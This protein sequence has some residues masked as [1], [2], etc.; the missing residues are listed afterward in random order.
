MNMFRNY[1]TRRLDYPFSITP[2]I[3]GILPELIRYF[4]GESEKTNLDTNRGIYLYGNVGIGKSYLMYGIR[5]F[6]ADVS[7]NSG[8]G[9]MVVST[10]DILHKHQNRDMEDITYNKDS[11]SGP[12]HILVN[13]FLKPLNDK[14]YGTDAQ[15]I[16]NHFIMVRYDIFQ[17][18][19]KLT[20]VTSNYPPLSKDAAIQDRFN[21]MFN[22]IKLDGKS[23]R[24]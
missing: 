21:E 9:F 16:I 18:R 6:I 5:K 17:M 1:L 2:A 8:N 11:I 3:H 13:E 23:L 20:H 14:I 7:P 12:R 19:N 10:E 4:L 22:M 15:D 24:V